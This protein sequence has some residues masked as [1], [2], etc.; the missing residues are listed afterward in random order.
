MLDTS[1]TD[2]TVS[3]DSERSSD[4]DS[5]FDLSD[6]E[7]LLAREN[8]TIIPEDS[9]LVIGN[10]ELQQTDEFVSVSV[11]D[12]QSDTPTF[13]QTNCD[14]DEGHSHVSGTSLLGTLSE[15]AQVG[16]VRSRSTRSSRVQRGRSDHFG[17]VQR[18]RIGNVGKVER[19]RSGNFQAQRRGRS[20][21]TIRSGTRSR[22]RRTR[23]CSTRSRGQGY[24]GQ[25]N[26]YDRPEREPLPIESILTKTD[27]V[28]ELFPFT[29]VTSPGFYVPDNIDMS[30]PESLFKLFF[31]DDIVGYICRASDEY[32]DM[33]Q[34]R[35]KVMYSYYKRMSPED[36]YR[37]LA[38]LIHFGY[39]KIPSY[40]LAW[41]KASLCYDPFVSNT[42]S[43]NRFEG[44]MYF[45]HVVN[46][47]DEERLKNDKNK[48]AKVHPLLD[49]INKKSKL[50]CQPEKE[51]SIDERMVRSKARFTFK[52]YIRNKP[53]KWGFKLWCLC[54]ASNGYTVQFSVYRGKTGE[55]S[56]KKGLSYD[57]V[58]HLMKDY[59]NQGRTLYVDNFYTSPTLA[60]DLFDLK[61]HL[62]GTLDKGRVGVPEE[63]FTMLEMLS[64]KSTCRGDG[65]YVRNEGVVYCAWK[66]TKCIV[67]LST[68]HPGHSQNTV[69]RNAKDSTGSH[70]KKDVPIPSPVYFYNKHMGGVDKSDQLIHY[71]NVL[72]QTK[73]Y[74]KTLFFHFIDIACVNA[75]IIHKELEEKPLSHYQFREKLARSLSNT[76][77]VPSFDDT[78]D[79]VSSTC[80]DDDL[81]FLLSEHQ[82]ALMGKRSY[83]AYC[84]LANNEMHYTTRQCAE[85]QVPLCFR[86]R[87]CFVNWHDSTFSASR[88]EWKVQGSSLQP[89]V[90]R[91]SGSIVKKGRGRRKRKRW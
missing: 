18:G 10:Q 51:L 84:K 82:F 85:C 9:D 64:A 37:M 48:L 66:D 87:N 69:K 91:P 71:Y 33:L 86:D 47:E 5:E 40:R 89:T 79:A 36:F 46:Q 90:G 57:V 49:H 83:C 26:H 15:Q 34:D 20:Q 13:R 8:D 88:K 67:M 31:S 39:K 81:D 30:D 72:R 1:L 53:T 75:Y 7:A 61:T 68:E 24:L 77:Y 56:S 43:R 76:R 55:V 78:H 19:E 41:S 62:T 38:I 22:G 27:A 54:N 32:A 17:R 4:S 73:K 65:F 2:S 42:M 60:I 29:P 11:C 28:K 23:S 58:L 45:L 59:L 6:P 63:V 52:Q 74:W 3:S 16:R 25:G 70:V 44:L 80:S 35:R 21:S 50:H 14:N 12:T